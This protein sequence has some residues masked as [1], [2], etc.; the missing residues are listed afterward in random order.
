VVQLLEGRIVII[1]GYLI[2]LFFL[3]AAVSIAVASPEC[4]DSG[5]CAAGEHQL[6]PWLITC[7]DAILEIRVADGEVVLRAAAALGPAH[8]LAA[9]LA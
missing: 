4:I 6:R 1:A 2:V 7:P 8:A 5:S 9:L 3:M